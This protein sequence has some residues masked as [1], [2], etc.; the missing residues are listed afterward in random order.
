MKRANC[1]TL[2]IMH[3]IEPC[4]QLIKF[5]YICSYIENCSKRVYRW[6]VYIATYITFLPKKQL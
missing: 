4:T 5:L 3:I 2:I 1:P 6:Y